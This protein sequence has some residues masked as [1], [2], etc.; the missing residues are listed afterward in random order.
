MT[1][2]AADDTTEIWINREPM[3]FGKWEGELALGYYTIQTR[4]EG[5]ESNPVFMWIDDT[6]PVM[7][8][9]SAPMASYGL[10]NIHSNVVGATIFIN[11]VEVGQ[12]P[13][14]V[15]NLPASKPCEVRL[16]NEGYKDATGTVTPIGNDMVDVELKMKLE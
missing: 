4:K 15:E 14:V 7:L 3:A 9:L 13:C 2:T 6:L 12:T 11:G 16:K 8:D 10:L 5:L 1:I